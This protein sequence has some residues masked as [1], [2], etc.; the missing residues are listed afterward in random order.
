M[1]LYFNINRIISITIIN[2]NIRTSF[3]V[4]VFMKS[5]VF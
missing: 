4:G 1:L 2:D 3:P 5:T